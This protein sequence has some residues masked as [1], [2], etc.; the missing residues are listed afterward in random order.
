MIWLQEHR[1]LVKYIFAI[2]LVVSTHSWGSASHQIRQDVEPG[3]GLSFSLLY[4]ELT[5]RVY[6]ETSYPVVWASAA[7]SSAFEFQLSLIDKAQFAPLFSE[8]FKQI[9]QY[10]ESGEWD[11]VDI[12]TTD[13]LLHYLSYV[14]NAPLI[15]KEWYFSEKLQDRLPEPAP[16][17]IERLRDSIDNGYLL[18]LVLSYAPPVG[19]FDQFKESYAVLSQ[20]MDETVPLYDQIG[21]KRLEDEITQKPILLERM[22]LVGVDISHVDPNIPIFDL[23]LEIAVKS[24]QKIH[25]IKSDGIIGPDTM[26]WINMPFDD[27]LRAIALNAE[28]ARLW[29]KDKDSLIVVNVPSFEMKYWEGGKEVFESKVVV[30]RKSRKTPLLEINLDSVI[31]NPT[32]NVPWKIMVK[33]IL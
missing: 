15:G 4:P 2:L 7:A 8:Q 10:K 21:L 32:W 17:T 25:G 22:A 5:Q 26:K 9:E 18:E 27:R 14:E 23:E 12:L 3:S 20:A 1:M 24:F 30:G 29:P 6:Q 33:D 28:R 16:E 11:K 31:L 13:A 19:N